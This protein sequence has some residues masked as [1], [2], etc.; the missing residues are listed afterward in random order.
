ML[1][2]R[3]TTILKAIV[4][5]FTRTVEPVGSKRLMEIV[6]LDV[7][8][9]TLRNEMA[10]LESMG[11][12]EKTHT[13]SGRI[14]SSQGY[15]YYVENLMDTG[16]DPAIEENLLK[17]FEENHY[18]AEE[19]VKRSC[20]ILS[21]MTNLTSIVLGP[22]TS[23][24]QLQHIQLIPINKKSA[25]CIFITNYGHTENKTFY[26][27]EEISI[28]DL[29]TCCE[30]LNEKLV[31]TPIENVVEEMQK[32]KPELKAHVARYEALFHAF[33]GAF[34]KFTTD[35]FYTSGASNMLYQPEFEDINQ[36]KKLM[37]ALENTSIWQSIGCNDKPLSIEIGNEHDKLPLDNVSVVS[38]KINLG[39]DKEGKLMVIGPTR[40]P[41]NKVVS[42]VECM[43]KVIENTCV[44]QRIGN[45]GESDGGK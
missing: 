16:L 43:S 31:G 7:S 14:P 41:Y 11:L 29:E 24:Q 25:V 35:N 5:E 10:N 17:I 2:P 27:D 36:L 21:Q 20:D 8:S 1:K 28:K 18:S 42:L 38:S 9:A 19:V 39:D 23:S 3:Q 4:E 37:S 30:I 12:L 26:F 13:S 15:R 32:I 22:E 40:M 34:I 44:K 6:D 45:R 33:T